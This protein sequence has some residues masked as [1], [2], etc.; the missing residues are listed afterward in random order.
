MSL[1]DISCDLIERFEGFRSAPYLDSANVPTIGFGTTYYEDGTRVTMDD[2]PI[3]NARASQIL[4][5]FVEKCINRVNSLVHVSLS[6]QQLSALVSFEYNTGHLNGSTLL[7][8]L[9]DGDMSAASEQFDRWIH[10]G[11]K[12]DQGLVKRRSEEKQLFLEGT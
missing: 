7:A 4:E 9:N 8:D 12:V 10:A 3:D 5:H 6:D 1:L 11:G 2:A